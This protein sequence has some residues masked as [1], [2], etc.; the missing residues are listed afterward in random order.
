MTEYQQLF[1]E[2]T[3]LLLSNTNTQNSLL[4]RA[5]CSIS[6]LQLIFYYNQNLLIYDWV[7]EA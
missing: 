6:S 5:N 4:E 3:T 2:D 7:D 1:T